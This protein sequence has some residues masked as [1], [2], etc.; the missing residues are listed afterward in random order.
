MLT[1]E[2]NMR[3]QTHSVT[4][5]KPTQGNNILGRGPQP[6]V[7]LCV[8]PFIIGTRTLQEAQLHKGAPDLLGLIPK[9]GVH[10]KHHQHRVPLRRRL[11]SL[12]QPLRPRLHLHRRR[13]LLDDARSVL[14]LY[15]W[16]GQRP[17]LL[18]RWLMWKVQRLRLEDLHNMRRPDS[19]LHP[20]R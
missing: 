4:I 2:V 15:R 11:T 12:P 16:R 20:S 13:P 9:R 14:Q 7:V 6:T 3:N 5:L 10:L 17:Q 18:L 19:T 8:G 1:W